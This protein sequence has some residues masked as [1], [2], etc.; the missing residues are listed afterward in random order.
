MG[1]GELRFVF[2]FCF[3]VKTKVAFG[4]KKSMCKYHFLFIKCFI[5][6]CLKVTKT[7][8]TQSL[9]YTL[10]L[11]GGDRNKKLKMSIL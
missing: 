11:T 5:L 7:H 9:L 2:R 4:V 1:R 6:G 3:Y 8:E 10:D